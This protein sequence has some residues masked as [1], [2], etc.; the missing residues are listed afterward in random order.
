MAFAGNNIHGR[1]RREAD[2]SDFFVA[3][4]EEDEQRVREKS[5]I[6]Q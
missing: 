5:K 1:K 4:E 6:D 2:E 3:G